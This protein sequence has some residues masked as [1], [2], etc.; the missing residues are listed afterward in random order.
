M[1]EHKSAEEKVLDGTVWDDFCDALKEAGRIVRSEQAP[2]DAFNQA[3]GYRYLTRLL[4]GGLESNLEFSDPMFPEL[5]CGAHETIKLGADN[6]DNR[7]ESAPIRSQH[8]YRIT[9]KR[10]TVN[11][12][13]ISTTIN[14]YGSGGTMEVTGHID[15]REMEIAED[16]TIGVVEI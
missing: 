9:G 4:R 11:Y 5:R 14:K 16:G 10:N 13:G 8:E 1:A 7:Y 6:P 2:Q 15:H 12:L 3:E